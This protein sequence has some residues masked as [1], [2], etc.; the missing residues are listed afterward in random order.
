MARV[1]I[2]YVSIEN[3]RLN[4]KTEITGWDFETLRASA[5]K[6]WDDALSR[7]QVTGGTGDQI[8]PFF[9]PPFTTP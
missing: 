6:A 9:I 3:A 1:G 5:S 2:S 8:K 4:L 7:I